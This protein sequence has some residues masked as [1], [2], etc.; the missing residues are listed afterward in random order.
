ME[1]DSKAAVL[2]RKSNKKLTV[3]L[4]DPNDWNDEA[5][6]AERDPI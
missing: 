4:T 3:A 2:I 1:Q 6:K 5:K